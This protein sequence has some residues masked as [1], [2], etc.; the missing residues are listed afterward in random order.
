M[1]KRRLKRLD[2]SGSNR[3]RLFA[4]LTVFGIFLLAAVIVVVIMRG[5]QENNAL[6]ANTGAS[7]YVKYYGVADTPMKIHAGK[8]QTYVELT[9]PTLMGIVERANAQNV[10]AEI[11]D[12]ADF[13]YGVVQLYKNDNPS[14]H[15]LA[16]GE[17]TAAAGKEND[18]FK[19]N[20]VC[21]ERVGDDQGHNG[22]LKMVLVS[23]LNYQRCSN[24]PEWFFAFVKH[25]FWDLEGG[26]FLCDQ[27]DGKLFLIKESSGEISTDVSSC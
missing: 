22:Y 25:T 19:S 21:L 4:Y 6:P 20:T 13:P 5:S 17:I 26:Y 11:A 15:Y 3:S 1:K 2:C 12:A 27:E 18:F 24:S 16:E 23:E 14:I 7:I 10:A 9:Q 8:V